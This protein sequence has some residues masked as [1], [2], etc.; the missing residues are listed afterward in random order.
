MSIGTTGNWDM[1][2]RSALKW[3]TD[4]TGSLL[5]TI[6]AII[7]KRP[8]DQRSSSALHRRREPRTFGS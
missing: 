8:A 4:N 3:L 1:P 6:A 7:C 5:R 2:S